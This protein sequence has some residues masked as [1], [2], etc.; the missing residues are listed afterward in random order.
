MA[1]VR[2]GDDRRVKAALSGEKF[3]EL[4]VGRV[5]VLVLVQDPRRVDQVVVGP[6]VAER[7]DAH[8]PE[9]EARVEEG[10]PLDAGADDGGVDAVGGG[11]LRGADAQRRP[12]GG[13][14]FQER[15][16][17]HAR[18]HAAYFPPSLLAGGCLSRS[19][20]P[21]IWR[22]RSLSGAAARAASSV[23]IAAALS[24]FLFWMRPLVTRSSWA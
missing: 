11:S 19:R 6:D 5:L 3:A 22:A 17:I 13:R 9:L 4:R 8:P 21:A 15:T 23:A 18:A 16:P 7:L 12:G 10:L 1:A 20:K 2:R 14:R 24:P